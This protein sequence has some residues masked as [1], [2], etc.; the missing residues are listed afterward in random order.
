M[1]L[2]GKVKNSRSSYYYDEGT[3]NN[4]VALCFRAFCSFSLFIFFLSSLFLVVVLCCSA[5][6]YL[7]C[8]TYYCD[9]GGGN[10]NSKMVITIKQ[11]MTM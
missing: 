4:N 3:R 2:Y 11:K 7:Y 6:C 5:F 1:E 10:N 8:S 9:G